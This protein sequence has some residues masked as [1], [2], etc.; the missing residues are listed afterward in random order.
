MAG[1]LQQR[2]LRPASEPSF[3]LLVVATVASLVRVADQPD[4]DI[5]IGGT[6]A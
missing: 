2:L 5:A 3:L 4:L 1:P 6:E